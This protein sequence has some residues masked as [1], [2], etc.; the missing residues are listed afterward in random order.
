MAVGERW[1]LPWA[2]GWWDREESR[3]V[4]GRGTVEVAV[5]VA[6]GGT[7]EVAVG[8]AVVE[9]VEVAVGVAVGGTAR[10]RSVSKW[11][12]ASEFPEVAGRQVAC[13]DIDEIEERAAIPQR[14]DGVGR[15]LELMVLEVTSCR[16]L[17]IA[18]GTLT[19]EA[20]T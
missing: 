3:S 4:R 8:V 20:E 10:S 18:Q 19:L 2:R 16:L 7:V 14:Y 15:F 5:G 1:T 12:W 13:R 6:V 17:S 9:P 11:D